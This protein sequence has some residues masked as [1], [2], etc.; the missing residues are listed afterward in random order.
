MRRLP[1]YFVVDVSESMVGG[2]AKLLTSALDQV[3]AELRQDPHCLETVYVSVI[4]FAGMAR[5]LTPLVDL[6]SFYPPKMP[7]GGGTAVGAALNVLMSE[8]DRSLV[9]SSADVK[10]DW[11]PLIFFITDGK[12]TDDPSGPVDIWLSKYSGFCTFVSFVI[13]DNAD[14]PLLNKLSD[15]VL[16]LQDSSEVE[17]KKFVDWVS[18]SIQACSQPVNG[19]E[20]GKGGVSLEKANELALDVVSD[21]ISFGRSD[22]DYVTL[23]GKCRKTSDPYLLKYKRPNVGML[24]HV[25]SEIFFLEGAYGLDESYFEWSDPHF[26]GEAVSTELLDGVSP[27]PHCGSP[28]TFAMCSCG[29]LLCLDTT[30]EAN[31]PWCKKYIKF[32]AEGTQ[33]SFDVIRG[34]G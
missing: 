21:D 14:T 19:A 10:G 7:I 26:K 22:P 5:P 9:K 8:M 28:T 33:S 27:C 4:A 16:A 1:I 34:G 25:S 11:S 24:Q 32:G 15:A 17:F 23:T 29:G 30:L 31:C 13:G 18:S 3:I 6:V 12:P 20:P 2:P